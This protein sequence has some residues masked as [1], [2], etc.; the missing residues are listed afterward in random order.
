MKN[1]FTRTLLS[2][3]AV[4]ALSLSLTGTSNATDGM[5]SNG[6]GTAAK[7]MSGA[8]AAM[9]LDTQAAINN[10]AAMYA[11]GDRFD[12]GV[13]YFSPRRKAIVEGDAGFFAHAQSA[14]THKSASES[15]Y[16][17][18]TGVNLDMGSY[19]LGVTLTAN[20]GM[21]TDYQDCIFSGCTK[22]KTGID[23]AQAMLGFTYARKV[24]DN[25]TFGITP[26]IA[27]QRFKASGLQGFASVSSDANNLTD[28][29]YSY[30]Y[31]FGGTVGLMANMT[32]KLDVGLTYKSRT[33]MTE[34]EKYKGLFAEGGDMDIPASFT[35]G[36]AYKATDDLTVAL[37]YKHIFYSDVRSI[38]NTNNIGA[39]T[40][41]AQ[42]GTKTGLGFGW[43]NMS[44]VKLGAQYDVDE[45]LTVRAGGSWNSMAMDDKENMF[46]IL[47]P[48]VPQYHLSGGATYK[49]GGGHE[50]GAAVTRAFSN[51]T[52]NDNNINHN[53]NNIE[54]QMDQWNVDVGYTY[55]F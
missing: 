17:P 24:A 4:T 32:D 49:L 34:F 11:L 30:S 40:G 8:G 22:Q 9:S 3:I 25:L 41:P 27:G 55:S 35:L 13:S 53:G 7:G 14:G 26:T 46:N 43:E 54:L 45:A 48:A 6:Y 52:D 5:F 42:L 20:G 51:T 21:N 38:S 47:A 1:M 10:P 29:G 50:I 37:D 16:I 2:G 31:G 44:V 33:Y 23:L 18:S 28:R 19:S 15:F 39:T 36:T 12:F